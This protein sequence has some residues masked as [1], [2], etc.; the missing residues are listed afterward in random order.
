MRCH[1]LNHCAFHFKYE[2][3]A[4]FCCRVLK[5]KD[6]ITIILLVTIIY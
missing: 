1:R 2:A 3:K 6:L 4:G 5:E